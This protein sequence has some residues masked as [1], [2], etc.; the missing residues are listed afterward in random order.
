MPIA[1]LD[2]PGLVVVEGRQQ[3]GVV[4]RAKLCDI[5]TSALVAELAAEL[6]DL[7]DH[8]SAAEL[9]QHAGAVDV[10]ERLRV[11]DSGSIV[12]RAEARREERAADVEIPADRRLGIPRRLGG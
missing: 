2:G 9:P 6:V 4:R 10:T 11:D 3:V 8:V 12:Q 5:G 1:S 7:V